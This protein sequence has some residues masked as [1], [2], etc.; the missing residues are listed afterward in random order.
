MPVCAIICVYRNDKVRV[1]FI[2]FMWAG[3]LHPVPSVAF[4]LPRYVVRDLA[5]CYYF[6][7]PQP[8]TFTT[9]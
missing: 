6:H 5:D 3:F 1:L 7:S 8:N 4:T 9:R 2:Y